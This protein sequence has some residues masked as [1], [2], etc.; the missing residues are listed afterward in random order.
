MMAMFGWTDPKMPAQL[1]RASEPEE[2]WNERMEKILAF[3]PSQSL[4]GCRRRTACAA[5]VRLSECVP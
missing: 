4:D 2:A 1:H 3:D 5:L